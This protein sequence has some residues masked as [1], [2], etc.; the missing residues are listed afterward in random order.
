MPKRAAITPTAKNQKRPRDNR[1]NR[2]AVKHANKMPPLYERPDIFEISD[3]DKKPVFHS[4]MH[5]KRGI[6]AYRDLLQELE[7]TFYLAEHNDES[8]ARDLVELISQAVKRLNISAKCDPEWWKQFARQ[9]R[10]WPL[11]WSRHK[12]VY[13]EAN[14]ILNRLEVGDGELVADS[15]AAGNAETEPFA[16]VALQL[17][18]YVDSVRHCCNIR[19]N[20]QID[21][22]EHVAAGVDVPFKIEMEAAQDYYDMSKPCWWR[23]AGELPDV[24]CLELVDGWWRV[25]KQAFLEAYPDPVTQL[26]ELEKIAKQQLNKD[27]RQTPGRIRQRILDILESRFRSLAGRTPLL[28]E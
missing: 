23:E 13:Q 3:K 24:L 19:L 28:P 4:G 7:H 16:R 2:K 9:Q 5:C 12:S 27:T 14:E 8:A 25:A 10:K 17:I 6:F 20:A 15:R 1:D 18:E 11:L 26:P 21:E 22:A